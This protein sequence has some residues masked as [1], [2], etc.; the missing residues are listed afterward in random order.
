M[1][2]ETVTTQEPQAQGTTQEPQNQSWKT[3][4]SDDL[5]NSPLIH[6]F[7]DGPDG[8]SKAFESHLNLEKMLGHEK[9]PIPKD[10]N[11][12]EGW[13][14]FSK[15]MGIP[16]RAEEY[17]LPDANIPE[18]M[19]GMTFDK[20]KFAEVVHAHKLTPD[21]AKGLWDA[22]TSMT[23]DSYGQ[24]VEKHKAQMADVVN[25]L[26]GEWGDAYD[27]NVE[28]GQMVIEKFSTDQETKDLLTAELTKDPRLVKFLARIG[29]EFSENKIGE[30]KMK[31]FSMAPDQAKNEIDKIVSDPDHPY[32]S[33][34][35]TPAEH[36]AAVDYVNSLYAAIAR[37][38]G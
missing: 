38:R 16:D 28:L 36:N 1:E 35:A 31:Q 3:S 11:D 12:E 18:S 34:K 32:N 25:R 8:L 22:Y 6:K 7:E 4:L 24:A 15:A 21:Q 13:S 37:G 33:E 27:T 17:G 14:R 2:I 19:K 20:G 29:N 30:F 26:R 23:I 9:V 5:R 10:A